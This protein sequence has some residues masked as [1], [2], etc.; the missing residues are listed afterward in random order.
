MRK[1][2]SKQEFEETIQRSKRSCR[3]CTPTGVVRARRLVPTLD[4]LSKDFGEGSK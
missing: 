2:E 3:F 1:V 4:D